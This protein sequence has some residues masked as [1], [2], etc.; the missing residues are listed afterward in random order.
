MT[1]KNL[2]ISLVALKREEDSRVMEFL[3]SEQSKT[4]YIVTKSGFLRLLVLAGLE[5]IAKNSGGTNG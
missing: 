3:R 5:A 4:T 1:E 2:V